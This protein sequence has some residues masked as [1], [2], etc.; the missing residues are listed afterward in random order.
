[1]KNFTFVPTLL[2]ASFTLAS[3][4]DG[5]DTA[6]S[7]QSPLVAAGPVLS[8]QEKAPFLFD[9][10]YRSV[11]NEPGCKPAYSYNKAYS[12]KDGD[13]VLRDSTMSIHQTLYSDS[14]CTQYVGLVWE[15]YNIAWAK[16]SA[17][18]APF[19]T[20]IARI[21]SVYT[22]FAIDNNYGSGVVLTSNPDG[23][24][25]TKGRN[26]MIAQV[27]THEGTTHQAL[28]LPIDNSPLDS[29]GY[30]TKLEIGEIHRH[31]VIDGCC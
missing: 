20:P 29:D 3:C 26:K 30:P 2:A 19:D 25:G 31:K 9:W 7:I 1:M 18:Q 6:T 10:W 11:L 4:G 17:E 13:M 23:S 28:Y 24:V 15:N 8:A 14:E 16:G 22:G 27:A 12:Y 21:A 5:V